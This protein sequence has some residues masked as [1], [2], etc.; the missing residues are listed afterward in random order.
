MG[1][2]TAISFSGT[3]TVMI[4]VTNGIGGLPINAAVTVNWLQEKLRLKSTLLYDILPD[5]YT[6]TATS[7]TWDARAIPPN[8]FVEY[9]LKM[10]RRGIVEAD[11]AAVAEDMN[12]GDMAFDQRAVPSNFRICS[13]AGGSGAQAIAQA[14]PTK[15]QKKK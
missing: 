5:H 1:L 15:K 9:R 14:S 11:I 10:C 8:G 2:N 7:C 4:T 3:D 13:L 6:T 12:T